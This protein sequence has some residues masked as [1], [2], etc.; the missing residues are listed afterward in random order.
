MNHRGMLHFLVVALLCALSAL[1]ATPA[2]AD[3]TWTVDSSQ[4][5]VFIV[6]SVVTT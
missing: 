1:L 5:T 2:L 4:T 6:P 3:V